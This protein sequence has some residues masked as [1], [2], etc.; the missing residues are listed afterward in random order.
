MM[1]DIPLITHLAYTSDRGIKLKVA[2]QI[3]SKKNRQCLRWKQVIPFLDA[4][5]ISEAKKEISL[6]NS[7][8][9]KAMEIGKNTDW[10]CLLIK[11]M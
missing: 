6:F 8:H 7:N 2:Y 3:D 11:K 9:V 5:S 10:D 4:I 1:H